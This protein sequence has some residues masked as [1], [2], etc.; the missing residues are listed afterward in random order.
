MLINEMLV[1]HT[2]EHTAIMPSAY[3][4]VHH[5]DSLTLLRVFVNSYLSLSFRISDDD[6][7]DLHCP[8]ARN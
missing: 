7:L 8:K 2:D 5:S 1:T 3:E 6:L 4:N